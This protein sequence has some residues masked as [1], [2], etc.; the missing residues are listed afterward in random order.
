MIKSIQK[1]TKNAVAAMEQG[2]QQVE[3]GT[4]EAAKSGAALRDILDQVHAV[5]MQV[6]Q[7]AT[8]A[9]QQTASTI[10]ISSNMHQITGVVE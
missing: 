1:E 8:T 2:V 4:D 10:E 5:A 9:E 3:S 7:I 6:N